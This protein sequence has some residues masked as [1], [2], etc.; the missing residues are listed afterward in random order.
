[1]RTVSHRDEDRLFVF[2]TDVKRRAATVAVKKFKPARK[3][4]PHIH[5]FAENFE[6]NENNEIYFKN[7]ENECP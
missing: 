7:D 3:T 2:E 6:N 5:K 4:E 1:M